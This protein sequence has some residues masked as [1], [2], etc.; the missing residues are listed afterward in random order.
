MCLQMV[1]GLF[2]LQPKKQE[3]RP[4][5]CHTEMLGQEPV[6]WLAQTG[7]GGDV[8]L[9]LSIYFRSRAEHL[10]S[11]ALGFARE[12]I[13]SGTWEPGAAFLGNVGKHRG[14]SIS[15]GLAECSDFPLTT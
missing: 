4:C 8:A 13:F 12:R 2:A 14:L 10:S 1:L 3:S 11:P 5:L 9:L 7:R 6:L 15:I